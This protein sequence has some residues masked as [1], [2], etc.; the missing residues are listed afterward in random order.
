[1]GKILSVKSSL[2]ESPGEDSSTISDTIEPSEFVIAICTT[3]LFL[4]H[5]GYGI[6]GES[7]EK[8][9]CKFWR[10]TSSD[11]PEKRY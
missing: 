3:G 7:I 11:E 2:E 6:G 4:G 1:M 9:C 10:A 5:T 8:A